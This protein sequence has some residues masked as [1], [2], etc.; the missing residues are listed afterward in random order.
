MILLFYSSLQD[1]FFKLNYLLNWIL[2]SFRFVFLLTE[3]YYLIDRCYFDTLE[4]SILG[5]NLV[6]NKF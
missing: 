4:S 6:I 1:G 3:L 5:F 2:I